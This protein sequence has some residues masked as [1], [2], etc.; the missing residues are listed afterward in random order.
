MLV[1]GGDATTLK[2]IHAY[3]SG[4]MSMG[5]VVLAPETG[6]LARALSV[7]MET[8]KAP[9]AGPFAEAN[10]REIVSLANKGGAMASRLVAATCFTLLYGCS[11]FCLGV[12][13][14]L[15]VSRSYFQSFL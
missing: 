2:E 3:L 11:L 10:L 4:P 9:R 12:G 1:I 8:G 5:I 6:G 14:V 15:C 7:F 13:G